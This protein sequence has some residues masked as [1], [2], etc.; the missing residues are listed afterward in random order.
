MI[1]LSFALM[2]LKNIMKQCKTWNASIFC[3]M[4]KIYQLCTK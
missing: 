3:G 4:A 2:L 1:F